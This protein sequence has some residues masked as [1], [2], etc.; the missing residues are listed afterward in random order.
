MSLQVPAE[1]LVERVVGRRMDPQTGKVGRQHGRG[2][3]C[4][5]L[6]PWRS[7]SSVATAQGCGHRLASSHAECSCGGCGCANFPMRQHF[8]LSGPPVPTSIDTAMV[9][10]S[11]AVLH[12]HVWICYARVHVGAFSAALAARS[13]LLKF[14]TQHHHCA[15][16]ILQVPSTT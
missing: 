7:R 5:A 10:V 12:K 2:C 16:C 1:L 8:L 6:A 13:L 14:S 15:A 9:Y 4:T 3:Y 11:V